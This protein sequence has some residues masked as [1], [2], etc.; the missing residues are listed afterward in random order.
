MV[1]ASADDIVLV[2]ET[3]EEV[4]TKLEICRKALESKGFRINRTKTEYIE[5]KFSNNN[6]ESR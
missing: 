3:R 1:Y 4:N 6:N 2:N 5:C